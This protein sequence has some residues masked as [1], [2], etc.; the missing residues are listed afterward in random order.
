MTIEKINF[1]YPKGS[2]QSVF[3]TEAMTAL[4][5]ASKTSKKVDECVELVNGV[6]Q[7]AIEAT[8]VVD[9]MRTVQ[10]QF[11]IE[12]ADIRAE[13]VTE[14]QTYIDGL[15]ASKA[16]FET[17]MTTDLDAFK[18]TTATAK[19]TYEDGLNASKATFETDMTTA[20]D[21]FEAGLNASKTTFESDMNTAVQAIVTNSETTIQTD[22]G[23][24]I[25]AL[26]T[27]GTIEGLL[28]DQILTEVKT[29]VETLKTDVNTRFVDSE[30]KKYQIVNPYKGK[31]SLALKGQLHCHTT[32]SDGVDSPT[33]LVSAYRQAGYKF[34]A[35]TD[36]DFITPD[37]L[38]NGI[39]FIPSVEEGYVSAYD[40]IPAY[41]VTSQSDSND[42]Q[43]MIDFHRQN[44]KL[45]SLAH[46]G[47]L[48]GEETHA[49]K[50]FDNNFVEVFNTIEY[51]YHIDNLLTT[52]HRVFMTAVDDCHN[53]AGGSF[54]Q[55][56]VVVHAE[57][58]TKADIL[59]ALRAG[60]F[61]ASTGNDISLELNGNII[62]AT[63][64]ASSK[65]EFIGKNGKVLNTVNGATSA[66]YTIQGYEL[67]VRVRA[68][69]TSDNKLAWTQPI[70]I[71]TIGGDN[72][73]ILKSFAKLKTAYPNKNI[74]I[75]YDWLYP[76][77]QRGITTLNIGSGIAYFLDHWRASRLNITVD[78]TGCHVAWDGVNGSDSWIEQH[79]E[80]S[81]A[82]IGKTVTVSAIVDGVV[83]KDTLTVPTT[84]NGTNYGT[85]FD[86][87]RFMVKNIGGIVGLVSSFI[88][89]PLLTL[90]S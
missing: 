90:Q 38:V 44:G 45:C 53:I 5:L 49:I 4:E 31:G 60:Q 82:L 63:S 48:S 8:A 42:A 85:V 74:L 50:L 27:D 34:I 78:A 61:Y 79:I 58:E 72:R 64:T 62:T 1:S 71:D 88:P 43:T 21:T 12:N 20:L 77:N 22:V 15:T 28:N 9:E 54:N 51:A 73:P 81:Q 75:N 2:L 37:P 18:A 29:D 39:I 65:F 35:V 68:T 36:H 83:Y 57:T 25:D 17:N 32:N 86:K 30:G 41:D 55:G 70:F 76:V 66:T 6:E 13:I 69:R 24:K 59:K 87:I 80:G 56:Y 52:G 46:P 19:T 7:I 3:D 14:N 84:L 10:E 26:V 89:Q 23:T 16:T 47:W 11:I 67:Y 40:H 33:A